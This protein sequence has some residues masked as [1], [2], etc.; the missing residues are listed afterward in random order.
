MNDK[1]AAIIMSDKFGIVIPKA[2]RISGMNDIVEVA[3]AEERTASQR[4]L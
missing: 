4:D 3:K 1:L 2:S